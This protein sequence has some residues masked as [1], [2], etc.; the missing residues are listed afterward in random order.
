MYNSTLKYDNE[1]LDDQDVDEHLYDDDIDDEED[2][3]DD[4]HENVDLRCL[5]MMET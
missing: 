1:K 2:E 4:V 3:D 5:E